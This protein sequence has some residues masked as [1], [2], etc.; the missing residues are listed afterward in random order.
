MKKNISMAN[1]GIAK[2][3]DG[4]GLDWKEGGDG[5]YVIKDPSYNILLLF[6]DKRP[7][8]YEISAVAYLPEEYGDKQSFMKCVLDTANSCGY[9]EL[10]AELTNGGCFLS[11]DVK[12]KTRHITKTGLKKELFLFMEAYNFFV[13]N[14]MLRV[15]MDN[16]PEDYGL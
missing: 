7:G 15:D 11:K 9:P 6:S 2:V 12:Y 16:N 13:I 3:L 5:M 14:V 1:N 10:R 4:L 8:V